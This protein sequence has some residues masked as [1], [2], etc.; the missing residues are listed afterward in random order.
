MRK[1][2]SIVL[3]L[4]MVFCFT[5]PAMAATEVGPDNVKADQFTKTD[6]EVSVKAKEVVYKVVVTWNDPSFEYN[7]GTW[8][9]TNVNYDGRDWDKTA[10]TF[11]VENYSNAHVKIDTEI[12][13]NNSGT[14]NGVDITLDHDTFQLD[15]ADNK[16]GIQRGDVD[17]EVVTVSVS[18]KPNTSAT[19]VYNETIT[20][21][22]S[23]VPAP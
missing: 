11:F 9:T 2:L 22:V 23:A 5:V 20:V 3:C 18:G 4:V 12:T 10:T 14:T 13:H 6:V 8:N 16:D 7:F 19:A 21:T 15:S 1:L 17:T